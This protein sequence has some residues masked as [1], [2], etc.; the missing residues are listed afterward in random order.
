M[1]VQPLQVRRH[2]IPERL[3][4]TTPRVGEQRR[5]SLVGRHNPIH[6]LTLAKPYDRTTSPD[7]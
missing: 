3:T 5:L 7:T 6:A 1:H 2:Q 4:I